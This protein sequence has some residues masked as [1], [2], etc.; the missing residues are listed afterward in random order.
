MHNDVFQALA[1]FFGQVCVQSNG[2]RRR[3]AASPLGLHSLHKHPTDQRQRAS[4]C[5][6]R[7]RLEQEWTH[8]AE[9]VVFGPDGTA[10]LGH[11]L[12][13]L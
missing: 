10:R 6:D 5:Q 1:R 9:V 7:H 4:G 8:S 11:C 2:A 12:T 3:I 13:R